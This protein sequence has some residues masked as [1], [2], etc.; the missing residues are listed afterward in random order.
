MGDDGPPDHRRLGFGLA[1]R[2]NLRPIWHM[3]TQCRF[4]AR[5]DEIDT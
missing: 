4:T 2:T 3:P 1:T 5:D